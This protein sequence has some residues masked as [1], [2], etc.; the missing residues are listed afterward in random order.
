MSF[1]FNLQNRL[2]LGSSLEV[3]LVLDL[4]K[5]IAGSYAFQALIF[6]AL[7]RTILAPDFLADDSVVDLALSSAGEAGRELFVEAG[8]ARLVPSI[9]EALLYA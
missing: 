6:K 8:G 7:A 9:L 2:I 4:F 5:D 1:A 3:H